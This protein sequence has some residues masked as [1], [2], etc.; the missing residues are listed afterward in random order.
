MA[1]LR[2]VQIWKHLKEVDLRPILQQAIEPVRMALVGVRGSGVDDLATMLRTDPYRLATVSATPL[3]VVDPRSQSDLQGAEMV[4]FV[5][6]PASAE[7][8]TERDL[9]VAL[10]GAH[11]PV[12]TI[13]NTGTASGALPSAAFWKAGPY[14]AGAVEDAAFLERE[15]VPAVLEALPDRH[16]ALARQLPLFRATV[17]RRL[18][19]ETSLA[20]ATYSLS[21]GLAG[22][23]PLLN[24]PLNVTDMAVLTKAQAF[25]V[26]RLGLAL[27]LSTRW[28]DYVREF[29]TV[30]GGGFMWRQLARTL[31]GLIPWLGIVPKVGVAYAGTFV[32][33]NVVWHWYLT[34][35][36][37]SKEQLRAVYRQA[38]ESG[39]NAAK[40]LGAG[41]P[42][43]RRRRPATEQP[44]LPRQ[45]HFCRFC[46]QPLE[47]GAEAC[48]YC[49][50]PVMPPSQTLEPP[51]RRSRRLKL[52]A[53]KG[54]PWKR[55]PAP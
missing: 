15:L 40:R 27:G 20:N 39:K 44:S 2:D 31:V 52:P 10:R 21:T 16:L 3:V 30:I 13:M 4:L 6:S 11:V 28:Q 25:L 51:A 34:G 35:R 26:Y 32:V 12:I 49:Y 9:A 23:I 5:V 45:T 36:H 55:R 7:A 33:G 47:P 54:W 17:A 24:I 22:V 50:A 42:R 53:F 38:I 46:G 41:F 48:A 43:R 14:L 18:I 37:L 29:G 19:E 1:G 8:G